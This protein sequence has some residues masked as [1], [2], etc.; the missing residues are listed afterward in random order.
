MTDG[1]FPSSSPRLSTSRSQA[2]SK[3]PAIFWQQTIIHC[4]REMKVTTRRTT[5][6]LIYRASNNR[7]RQSAFAETDDDKLRRSLFSCFVGL[8]A[9][10]CWNDILLIPFLADF[11]HRFWDDFTGISYCERPFYNIP[12]NFVS[13]R[14]W[15]RGARNLLT[16]IVRKC[17]VGIE[18]HKTVLRK[19]D[20]LNRITRTKSGNVFETKRTCRNLLTR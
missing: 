6:W 20:F 13:H 14:R 18:I 19:C 15:S 7:A 11:T 5:S 8:S 12:N 16:I 2:Q 17:R 10:R 3:L 1:G 9:Q 4:A